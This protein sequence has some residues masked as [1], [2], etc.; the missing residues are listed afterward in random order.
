MNLFIKPDIPFLKSTKWI[1]I[2]LILDFNSLSA[3]DSKMDVLRCEKKT[4]IPLSENSTNSNRQNAH[5]WLTVPG[6]YQNT[7]SDTLNKSLG[8]FLKGLDGNIRTLVCWYSGSLLD[9]TLAF[10]NGKLETVQNKWSC[11]AK[12]SVKSET[13]G[14]VADL[15]LTF[16][17][18]QGI[19]RSAGVAAAFDFTNWSTDNYILVPSMIYG[20]NRFRILPI[21]YPPYI[22]NEKDRPPDMPITVTNIPHL[23]PDGSHAKVELNTGNVATPMLSFFNSKEKR[24][25]ILLTEQDTRFGNNGL[26]VEEDAGP[27]SENKRM[28]FVVSAPGVREQR[29]VMC[30]FSPSGDH[31]ADW[32][33]GDD[34]KLRFKIFSFQAADITSFYEKVFDVRKALSGKN[35]YSCITPY[36]AAAYLILEHHDNDRWFEDGKAAYYSN[37]PGDKNPYQFQLGWAGAPNCVFPMV[38]DENPERLRRTCLTLENKI[39]KAQGKTGLFYAIYRDGDFLGDPHGKMEERR[40]ISMPRRSMIVLYFGLRTFNLMKQ[41]G[42]ADMIS[43]EWEKSL[44]NCADGLLRVWYDYG[45]FGQ[46]IDVE[47]GKMEINGSTAGSF[48][49]VPLILAAKYFDNPEYIKVAEASMKMYYERDFLKGYAGGTSADVLQSPESQSAWEMITSCL[50]LYE[51]TGKTEWLERAKFAANMFSTWM[52]SYDYHFPKGSAMGN[53]GTHAAGSV[54]ASSQNNHST[55]GTFEYEGDCLFRLFRATGD[56]RYAEMHKDQSHNNIQYVGTPYN[57]LR[58]ESGYVTERVQLSDWE[59]DN[60]GSVDYKDSNMGW[61]TQVAI[62]C[63]I[64]PGIYLHTDDDTF[65]VMD[66]VEAECIRRDK[67]GVVLKITNPTMYDAKVSI[68]AETAAEAKKP[69]PANAF[70]KWPKI[71]VN[72]GQTRTITIDL[73]G[74]LKLI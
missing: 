54:F 16:K 53:A 56:K 41:H 10:T 55:P 65:W 52:V 62:N 6:F 13:S 40:T 68:L 22:H 72:A 34:L 38:I 14:E 11:E 58:H 33:A 42:H 15:I 57:P 51:V 48:A 7:G 64:N 71:E 1:I 24:G 47:T 2:F 12:S 74:Q 61:E 3:P 67:S 9:S 21:G 25:F 60:I 43:P 29:Y 73:H 17:L 5:T 39:F 26:F 69:M 4:S 28:T 19:A 36:S 66:H 31:G 45:Q 8:K 30:G 27:K 18:K 20:G 23:N 35:T 70:D 32:K 50:A 37:R 49:G 44:R 46:Y 63:L 59:G